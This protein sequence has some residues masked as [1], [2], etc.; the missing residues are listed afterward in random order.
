MKKP[1]CFVAVDAGTTNT[2]VWLMNDGLPVAH[3]NAMVGVRDTAR[4]GH[5]QKLVATLRQ[6]IETV[7]AQA[8]AHRPECIAAAGMITSPLGL[9]E[10]PHVVAPADAAMIARQA[11]GGVMAEVSVLPMILFGGVRS[12]ELASADWAES[13]VMR[14]EE[15]LCLGMAYPVP[16]TVLNLG[17][18]WKVIEVDEQGHITRSRT[19]LSG[20][21]ILATQT[22]TILAS[23]LPNDKLQQL[24]AEWFEK[25]SDE[26]DKSGLARALFCVRLLELQGKTSPEQRMSFLLGVYVASDLAALRESGWLVADRRVLLTGSGAVVEAWSAALDKREIGREVISPD[27]IEAHYLAGIT[28]LLALVQQ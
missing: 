5:N 21:L 14:G 19:T 12:G 3:A 20:E 8:P 7:C 2:R 6:L 25:G 10:V 24:D 18:H 11:W 17:S 26:W 28:S 9:R 16:F 22:T 4:D 27:K 23:A 1:D 13:D 15:T